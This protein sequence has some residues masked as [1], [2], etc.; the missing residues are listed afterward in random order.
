M[1]KTLLIIALTLAVVGVGGGGYYYFEVYQ[2]KQYAASL[3]S[4][5]QGLESVGLQPDTS[6]LQGAA[7]YETAF[8]VLRE[9]LDLVESIQG[10]LK[11][12]MVPK[13][14]AK[15]HEEFTEYIDLTIAQHAQALKLADFMKKANTLIE[16]LTGVFQ[17]EP[18]VGRN[19]TMG[20]LRKLLDERI[21]KAQN[22]GV[23]LFREEVKDLATSSYS[24]LQML[25]EGGSP[26][27]DTVL[28]RV[29]SV[30]SSLPMS[31]VGNLFSPSEIKQLE[32]Y[33]K[34]LQALHADL[35]TLVQLYSAYEV[36]AFRYFPDIS[37]QEASE[38]SIRFYNVV[39]DL[40]QRYGG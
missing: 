24:K 2:P 32:G 30:N 8:K 17:G 18:T 10:E 29:R 16:A 9:R 40:K 12:I 35:G 7:D 33:T 5:Y 25:W 13:R 36:L 15:I 3:L 1:P 39:Q 6:S 28:K 14:M 38:R 37:P 26:A 4:L 23:E 11:K 31:Q 20:D 34:K 21:P 22:A 19:A 27:F